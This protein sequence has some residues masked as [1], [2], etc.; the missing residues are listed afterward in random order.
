[1]LYAYQ[2]VGEGEVSVEEGQEVT[3]VEPDGKLEYLL[4]S[5]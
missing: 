2:A 4:A 3:I 1:M 5:P